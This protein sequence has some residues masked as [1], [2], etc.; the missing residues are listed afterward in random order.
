MRDDRHAA[1]DDDHGKCRLRAF[2]I[3]A[4][5]VRVNNPDPNEPAE[6]VRRLASG[7][8]KTYK[9]QAEASVG[10]DGSLELRPLRARPRLAPRC[11]RRDRRSVTP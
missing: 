1:A 4:D 9:A 2:E 10:P 6:I 5:T 11:A 8:V 3:D 7:E